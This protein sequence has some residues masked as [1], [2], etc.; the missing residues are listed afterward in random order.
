MKYLVKMLETLLCLLLFMPNVSA[1]AQHG[2]IKGRVKDNLNGEALPG[3]N[4][5]FKEFGIGDASDFKG[6]FLITNVPVGK[7]TLTVS[8][9]GYVTKEITVS[10]KNGRVTT[11]DIELEPRSLVGEEVV[12]TAQA[13][14]QIQAMNQQI[15]AKTIKNIV[16]SKTIQELPEAN[17]AEA[18]GRL[19]GVSLVRSGGEG[20]KVILRG[21]APKYSR[22]QID[23]VNMAST[24]NADRSADLSMISTQMLEGIEVTKSIMADQEADAT[25]GIVNFRLKE[26]P[27]APKFNILSEGAYNGLAK[28]YN[29]YK[30]SLGGSRRFLDSKLGVYVQFNTEKRNNSS[31]KLGGISYYQEN[32]GAP[33]QTRSVSLTDANRIVERLGATLVMDYS[34]PAMKIKFSN[35]SSRINHD[36]QEYSIDYDYFVN[37]YGR[38]LTDH[39][40]NV[41]VM[42]NNLSIQQQ[43]NKLSVKGSASY[44]VS[45]SKMPREFS[46]GVNWFSD[47]APFGQL[48]PDYFYNL[49]P[50]T[51]PDSLKGSGLPTELGLLRHTESYAKEDELTLNLDFTLE[52]QITRELG[53]KI[54][55]GGRYK[56]KNKKYDKTRYSVNTIHGAETAIRNLII[57]TYW[58]EI[59]EVNRNKKNSLAHLSFYPDF[60]DP[61]YSNSNFLG[62]RFVLDNMPNLNW[63]KNIDRLA[64]DKGIYHLIGLASL[65]DNYN[66]FEDYSAFY[67]EPEINIGTSLTFSP[68]LRYEKN[69]TEYTGYRCDASSLYPAWGVFPSDT[70]TTVRENEFLLPMIHLFYQPTDWFNVKAG[71]TK[72]LQRPDYSDITPNWTLY[73]SRVSWNN[74]FLRPEKSTN[75]DLQLSFFSDKIGLFSIAGFHK[76]IKDMIFYTGTRA[77]VDTSF[78]GLPSSERYKRVAFAVNN[79]NETL[80]YGFE[81]E[82]KSNFWWLPGPLKGLVVSANYTR[83]FSEAKYFRNEIK[84]E[85]DEYFRVTLVNKDTVYTSPMIL[86]PDHLLNFLVGY[87]YKG[88]SIRWALRYKSNIFKGENWYED[89]RTYSTDFIRHDLSV[90]QK[91]PVKGLEVYLNANNLTNEFERDVILAGLTKSYESYGRFIALGFRY[92]Y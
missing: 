70:V 64:L 54:K 26:A 82:W 52:D 80:D 49:D 33:V 48:Q 55:F 4:L 73:D 10:I 24:G 8:Y 31:D 66:G 89:L 27:E 9:I 19:P 84:Q 15:S 61:D 72:T 7:H 69:R 57:D 62:G 74:Y 71:Y 23:G 21:L 86:Q 83:N 65:Q 58:D 44:A 16:S 50:F 63:F 90:V 51:I 20:S 2:K 29:N 68:G 3:A 30:L 81:V 59:S 40:S 92:S 34:L 35:F 17:A 5:I 53:Y 42:T 13:S 18:V 91:L 78:F 67:I 77:I 43:F 36:R 1:L 60:V 56:H 79:E 46:V 76:R 45:E 85:F 41:S 12:A 75:L 11:R 47:Q 6:D 22:I 14:A 32:V 87:D 88:F 37:D 38:N 28:S 39:S 25:G